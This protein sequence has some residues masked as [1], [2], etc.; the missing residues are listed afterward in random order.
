MFFMLMKWTWFE[1][2][3]VNEMDLVWKAGEVNAASKLCLKC[4]ES[5]GIL[6]FNLKNMVKC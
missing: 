1:M 5:A 3:K 4:P 6:C 2:L